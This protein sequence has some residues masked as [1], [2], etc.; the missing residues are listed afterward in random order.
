M[1]NLIYMSYLIHRA[2]SVGS[3]TKKIL[4]INPD[5]GVGDIV[6]IVRECTIRRGP[7][8][9]EFGNS[10]VIDED[11]ALEMARATLDGRVKSLGVG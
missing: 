11:R 5:L 8:A 6:H 7:E 1:S 9:D 3:L 10:E 4:A 2:P